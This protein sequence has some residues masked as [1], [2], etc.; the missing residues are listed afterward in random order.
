MT[1]QNDYSFV[2]RLESLSSYAAVS[3]AAIGAV[4]LIGWSFDIAVLK[5]VNPALI[6]MKVNTAVAFLLSGFALWLLQSKNCRWRAARFTGRACAA[7]VTA[8]GLLTLLE[9][10]F[11]WD[12]GIDQLLFREPGGTAQTVHP[13]RMAPNTALN[14][15][16]IGL[17]LL[18][19]D[20]R[21][22]R[23]W[24]PAQTLIALVGLIAGVAVLGYV[25]SASVLFTPSAAANPMSVPAAV[26]G[27]LTFAGL[28]L[29]RPGPGL[30]QLLTSNQPGSEVARQFL[31]PILL[32]PALIDVVLLAGLRAGLYREDLAT[33]AHAVLMTAIFL[34]V[35]LSSVA[36]VNRAENEIQALRRG[37]A[38]AW[39][40]PIHLASSRP[41]RRL[42]FL[43]AI[44][45]VGAATLV[46]L[47]FLQ[48]LG[49]RATYVTFYP[50]VMLASLYGG[51]PAGLLAT[52][53]SGIAADYFWLEP[54]GLGIEHPADWLSLAIFLASGAMISGVTEA[55]HRARA[56]AHAAELQASL[57]AVRERISRQRQVA[58]DAARMGWWHYDPI[59]RF[60]SW[61]DRYRDIFGVADYT[62]PNDE[63]MA[64][65][66]H[67]EDRP[68]L[69]AKVEAALDPASPQPYAAEYRINR[70]DGAMR[71]VEAH[72]VASFEG[73]GQSRRAV[74][75]VGTVADITERK[76]TE[77]EREITV[78]FLRLINTSADLRTLIQ[79]VTG[80]FREQS[81]CEA[82]GV[83]LS[84]EGDYP[85]YE[86]RGFP[87][88]FVRAENS[89]CS[90]DT[91][92]QVQN[93][94]AGN[95]ILACM[96]G[97]V[98]CGRIDPTQPF[99]TV[100]G[101]FWTNSTTQLLASTTDAERQARTRNRCN[102]EGYESVALVPL[103]AGQERLGLLQLNDKRP[104]RFTPQLVAFWERLAG[105]LAVAIAKARAEAALQQ[106]HDELELRVQ[107]RTAELKQAHE[108]VDA[109][110]QRFKDVL[111]KL[112]AYLVLL[113][114]DY[115]VPFANRF[116]EER[117]G[118]AHGQRCYEYLF[119]RTE[120]CEI[121]ET[122]SVLKTKAPHH[123]EWTGPDGRN[124]DIYDFPFTDT[125]GSPLI[126]E[127]GLD[128]TER[129]KAEE[130]IQ[131]NAAD[132]Q[133]SNRELEHFA[134]V[135][136][137]DLQEPLRSL[138][139]FSQL[140]AR[141]YQGKLDRDADDFIEFIV[142]GA[143]RMQTLINDLLA[144][145]RIGTRGR[146]FARV[147][148]EAMIVAAQENLDA[149]I[150]ESGAIIT[151]DPLP[152]VPGDPT[153]LT[154]LFQN[155]FSNAIKF[156]RQQETPRIH[157][158]AK[159]VSTVE[160]PGSRPDTASAP[161]PP[162]LDAQA[163][164]AAF[165]RRSLEPP[166]P[167]WQFSVRDNGLGIEPQY[168]DRIFIIFQRLHGREEY[169]GTG[170]GLAICKK[171]VERHGG[172]IWVE[173]QPGQGSTFNFTLLDRDRPVYGHNDSTNKPIDS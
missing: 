123:W 94:A 78:Q 89:L 69:W 145:S 38:G 118:K 166:G 45:I 150:A 111:D 54:R 16:L 33:A 173:S 124:Y 141:R 93:D 28:F 59:T 43:W 157:V 23:G 52:A 167:A 34:V 127:V 96:C 133:R 121:C 103:R 14:F 117:F 40:A 17:S 41:R 91:G 64:Q 139:S 11:G 152:A 37:L 68:G 35:V 9:N 129:K 164:T 55:M 161:V 25:Y 67:P 119:N 154:Q 24:R 86:T 112:P 4:V 56:R 128:I 122:Y 170:I 147:E 99:F 156:R 80:F 31:L 62:R 160:D 138:S 6:S 12:L 3:V 2:H 114:P 74:S 76:A 66:I 36:S 44:A 113:S 162:A 131:R 5:S 146:P 95:P 151:H 137:H 149:A 65:I 120:P 61:D 105:Y 1:S 81:D 48:A 140:L 32:L 104:G 47:G 53:L 168:F 90:R 51:L 144:F 136:S 30:V 10:L 60:A 108:T 101:S 171:I 13:G 73:D 77:R 42:W 116:F 50:A 84:E 92:G 72:G 18:L 132:L 29:A 88:E 143:T 87:Q 130:E 82:V 98:I 20:V 15:L 172:C 39:P 134:Y 163:P 165:R 97:N 110:R 126:M 85:Y 148:C 102:G 100:A 153:Q 71:W 106:A 155:L 49:V 63:I 115:H 22:R 70:P 21:T 107:Q 7:A 135:A 83:R 125:D 109:E 158:S 142:E 75:F 27:L 46:R 169:P 58:L 26:A 57:T 79:T 8:A 159:R 19:L